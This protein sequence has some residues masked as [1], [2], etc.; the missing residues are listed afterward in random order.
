MK[1]KGGDRMHCPFLRKLNVKYCGLYGMKMIPLSAANAATERC[2]S[3]EYHECSLVRE[4]KEAGAP[5]D[6]CP[7]LCVED[8]H[9]CDLAPVRKLVPCN[10]A[11]ASRCGGDGHRYCD[12]YLALAEP[13]AQ[14]ASS[15][16]GAHGDGTPTAEGEI[17]QPDDLAYSA[18]HMWLDDGDGR[19]VHIGVDAFFTS[20]LGNVESVTFP[21]R[22]ELARPS[23]LIRVGGLD[24]EMV[25]PLR[26]SEIET[27]A[28]LAGA[29]STVSQDP[30]GRGWLFAGVPG[31]D[32][33]NDQMNS[34]H[35]NSV[36]LDSEHLLRGPTARRW[37][38]RE[39]E[40]LTR[41]VH[42]CLDERRG[43]GTE[44]ATDGGA[45]S[46][47]LTDL[48][49]RRTLV[50]LHHEFFSARNGGTPE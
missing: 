28:H 49:D 50:R 35:L 20:T 21:V 40:R 14:A 27:N 30:Y 37:M 44:L 15:G 16:A 10:K 1:A 5:Q 39:R 47:R 17:P 36:H 12:L 24:L 38:Q 32:S 4:S 46:G 26:L 34:V 2:L 41:F 3:P 8:V 29:P 25:F 43:S 31:P 6:H 18:N 45:A 9:Y 11:A 19:R 48:L 33:R 22:R 7:H 23:A 42:T 13:R